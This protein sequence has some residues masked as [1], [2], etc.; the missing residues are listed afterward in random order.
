VRHSSEAAKLGRLTGDRRAEAE[1]L[2][3]LGQAMCDSGVPA[4]ARQHR[5]EAYLILDDL[6]D[7]R[8]A[9]LLSLLDRA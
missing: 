7:P 6:G 9:A 1:A 5:Y 3:V 2:E 8:A 4:Q